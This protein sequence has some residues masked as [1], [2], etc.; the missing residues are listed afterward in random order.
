MGHKHYNDKP[1][2]TILGQWTKCNDSLREVWSGR[3][4]VQPKR[5]RFRS[6][7]MADD[8]LPSLRFREP[9]AA[10][11]VLVNYCIA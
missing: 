9:P 7:L 8:I 4:C 11:E 1:E 3:V 2:P 5:V 6:G 10:I